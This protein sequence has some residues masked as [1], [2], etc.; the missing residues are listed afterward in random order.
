MEYDTSIFN[1]LPNPCVILDTES[2]QLTI[3]RINKAFGSLCGL[4][5]E[6][7]TGKN[8]LEI[9][10]AHTGL[11]KMEWKGL[12]ERAV[13]TGSSVEI[14]ALKYQTN[15]DIAGSTARQ[16]HL[17]GTIVPLSGPNEPVHQLMCSLTDVTNINSAFISTEKVDTKNTGIIED[18]QHFD[19]I[20]T[21]EANLNSSTILWSSITKEIYEVDQEFRPSF[22]DVIS[23]FTRKIEGESFLRLVKEAMLH[24]NFFD[25]ELQITTSKGSNRLIRISGQAVFTAGKCDRIRG[26]V[27]DITEKEDTKYLLRQ[28]EEQLSLLTKSVNGIFWEADAA[29]F[30]FSFVSDHVEDILGYTKNEWLQ[31][32]G[33]WQNHIH[34][35]DL[36]HAVSYCQAQTSHAK[37]HIFDYR[38]IKA[39]GN[40]IWIKDIVSVIV[41][42]D[43]PTRLRGL[44][45]DITDARR[46]EELAILEKSILQINTNNDTPLHELLMMYLLGIESIF[47][48]MQCSVHTVKDNCLELGLAP[49]IPSDY[50]N[51]IHHNKPIGPLAGSC[52]TAAFLKERVIVSDITNDPKWTNYVELTQK[53]DF[54]ACWSQP[55]IGSDDKVLATLG[56]YYKEVKLP[57]EDELNVI[58][59]CAA[60]L[61]VIM[62]SREKSV[63]LEDASI[64]MKQGQELAGFGNW[65]WDILNNVV[66]WSDELYTIYGLERTSFKATFEGY[67]E[68]LHPDDRERVIE[69]IFEV[70]HNKADIVFE[71]R[72][73]RPDGEIRYLKS[74]GRVKVDEKGTPVKMIGSCLDV[75]ESRRYTKAIEEQNEN[76]RNIAFMQSHV[77]RAPLARLMGAV[78]LIKDYEISDLENKEILEYIL[79]S[80]HELDS[81]IREISE[82]TNAEFAK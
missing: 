54:R 1:L 70:L 55:I 14:P 3:A 5:D 36:Y 52:G 56:F 77:V 30:E 22:D 25:T 43:K 44:M 23:F 59:R 47:P 66:R 76:M 81:I 67:Q 79:T 2:D 6:K 49:S 7:L 68:L 38:M 17:V 35:D 71:E 74:W 64:V 27:Q 40:V 69:G 10:S 28:Y 39:D 11:G 60:I 80:A 16:I 50:L 32:P 26:S 4:P 9:F 18:T 21:W 12:I 63:L 8:F 33:F 15:T 24:G 19:K 82:K 29:T 73:V 53:Y 75:T 37:D 78:T 65:Q 57:T 34:P 62:E 72:I 61:K 20:G 58:E 45:V 48:G 41:E 46:M 42:K 51:S 31:E 13:L